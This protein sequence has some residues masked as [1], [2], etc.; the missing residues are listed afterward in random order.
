MA[1][2]QNDV[3]A[4]ARKVAEYL[5]RRYAVQHII[6][7]GSWAQGKA[8]TWSDIDL[9]V[10]SPDFEGQT[11]S[12]RVELSVEV[13]K[14]CSQLVELHP[15]GPTALASA[16]PSNFAGHLLRSGTYLMKDGRWV[17][18]QDEPAHTP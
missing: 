4:V 7:F 1:Q 17:V 11:L 14:A 15:L 13:Q 3:V 6:L 2:D 18:P 8:G 5:Q 16:R 12:E 10:V 9:A